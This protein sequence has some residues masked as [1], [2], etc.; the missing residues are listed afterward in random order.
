MAK[1]HII[2]VK[3]DLACLACLVS[4]CG[5]EMQRACK[6][7]T[8]VER[9]SILSRLTQSQVMDEPLKVVS[10]VIPGIPLMIIVIQMQ[11]L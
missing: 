7:Q 8:L 11:I 9:K 6:F 10:Q 5:E 1:A 3:K 4:G 2:I